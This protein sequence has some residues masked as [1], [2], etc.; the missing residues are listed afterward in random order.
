[1]KAPER[2]QA[3]TRAVEKVER[4][5]DTTLAISDRV[6]RDNILACEARLRLAGTQAHPAADLLAQAHRLL[7]EMAAQVAS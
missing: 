2:S 5:Q 1:V 4:D 6:I 3:Q 7:T